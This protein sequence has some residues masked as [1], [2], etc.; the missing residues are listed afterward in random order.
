MCI[1]V[2]TMIVIAIAT[3]SVTAIAIIDTME[4]IL[5]GCIRTS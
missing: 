1:A 2:T 5:I 4:D 3:V